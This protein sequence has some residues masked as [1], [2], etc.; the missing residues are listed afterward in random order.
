MIDLRNEKERL[1][2]SDGPDFSEAFLVMTD[3]ICYIAILSL[4]ARQCFQ[5]SGCTIFADG[6]TWCFTI[7]DTQHSDIRKKCRTMGQRIARVYNGDL[8]HGKIDREGRF[9]TETGE[10]PDFY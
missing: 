2:L 3:K 7:D 9:W 8:K 4:N 5:G 1:S 10:T 6:E